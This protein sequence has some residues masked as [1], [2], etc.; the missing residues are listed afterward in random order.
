MNM[1][2]SSPDPRRDAVVRQFLRDAELSRLTSRDLERQRPGNRAILASRFE[3]LWKVC[4]PHI[5]GADEDGVEVLTDFRYVDLGLKV[6]KALEGLLEVDKED[7]EELDPEGTGGD[8][9][10]AKVIDALDEMERRRREKEA[11]AAA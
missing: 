9:N 1:H 8:P 4:E 5:R 2:V 10:R 7:P 6:L 11:G 3:M